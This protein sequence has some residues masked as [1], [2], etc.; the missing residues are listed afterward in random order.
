MRLLEAYVEVPLSFLLKPFSSLAL[1]RPRAAG[2]DLRPACDPR[3]Q[4]IIE[5]TFPI[6]RPADG[7]AG[8]ARPT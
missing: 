5:C 8:P 4:V 1:A 3:S 2:H 7:G 6:S